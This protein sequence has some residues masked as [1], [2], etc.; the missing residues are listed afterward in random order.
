MLTC[1]LLLKHKLSS[2]FL[3]TAVHYLL[4][5][6]DFSLLASLLRSTSEKQIID[7]CSVSGLWIRS[8]SLH[9]NLAAHAAHLSKGN[10]AWLLQPL[11]WIIQTC[12]QLCAPWEGVGWRKMA[13][14]H[15]RSGVQMASS[16][17]SCCLTGRKI[18]SRERFFEEVRWDE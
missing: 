16:E 1:K 8:S 15:L 4:S 5:Q 7:L 14:R 6:Q 2:D 10:T 17:E 3:R 9:A 11:I 18:S 12:K 13:G